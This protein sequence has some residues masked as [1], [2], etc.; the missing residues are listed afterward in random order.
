MSPMYSIKSVLTIITLLLSLVNCA[1][2]SVGHY[3]QAIDISGKPGWVTEGSQTIKT[4]DGRSFLGVGVAQTSGEFTRQATAANEQ[5]KDEIQ[6]MLERF[7]EVVSRD[8]LASGAAQPAGFLEHE[9]SRYIEEMT[10]IV[11]PSAKIKGHWVD[12]SSKRIFAIAEIDYPNVVSLLYTSTKVNPGFKTYL[13]KQGES[14]FDR[15][16]TQH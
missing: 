9:A 16:A 7:I 8:Y 13:K 2:N 5:A 15:I 1:S 10:N 12:E 11:L 3:N 14:V 4:P 6:R